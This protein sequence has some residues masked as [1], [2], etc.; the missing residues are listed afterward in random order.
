MTAQIGGSER[1]STAVSR[2]LCVMSAWGIGLVLRAQDEHEG[3]IRGE[4]VEPDE[5][6]ADRPVRVHDDGQ[7]FVLSVW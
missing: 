1:G 5:S 6:G 2:S 3:D 7:M 4:H